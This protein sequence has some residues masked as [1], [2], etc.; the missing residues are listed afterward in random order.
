MSPESRKSIGNLGMEWALGDEAGFTSDKMGERFVEGMEK[1]FTTW[2]PREK[3]EFYK[4]T[5]FKSRVIKHKVN[6]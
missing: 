3:F 1:L 5:D 6:Y 2:T 4:D